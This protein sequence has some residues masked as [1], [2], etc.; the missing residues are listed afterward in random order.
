SL[1]KA[2]QWTEIH[3]IML[4]YQQAGKLPGIDFNGYDQLKN[5]YVADGAMIGKEYSDYAQIVTDF[6]NAVAS[7]KRQMESSINNITSSGGGGGT[8]FVMPSI[9]LPQPV[10]KGADSGNG[11]GSGT[12]FS[13]MNDYMWANEAVSYLVEKGII[14]GVGDN[15]FAP[16]NGLT[17]EQM[18]TILVRTRKIDVGTQKSTFSDVA[19]DRWS[20]PYVSAV[21]ESGLMVGESNEYFGAE[22]QITRN[23]YAVVMKRL[24]DLYGGKIAESPTIKDYAD[25]SSI[26]DWAIESVRYMKATGLMLG[27][28]DNQFAGDE[29]I[30]RAYACDVLYSVLT[31]LNYDVEEQQ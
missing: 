21:Y 19:K 20:Y 8:S 16:S 1:E 11:G 14:S 7:A 5:Q 31:A 9:T 23:Q 6:N 10:E 24:I 28:T 30:T 12:V 22:S 17:R 3:P 29:I 25:E 4:K 27:K 2:L 15:M 26:P 18:S 13:D